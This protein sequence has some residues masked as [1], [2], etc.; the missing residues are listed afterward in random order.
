MSIERLR[1]YKNPRSTKWWDGESTQA[2]ID[3]WSRRASTN[4]DGRRHRATG[5]E[6]VELPSTGEVKVHSTASPPRCNRK[7]DAH[8]AGKDDPN[9]V[10][11]GDFMPGVRREA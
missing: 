1:E 8:M 4:S 3:R 10:S 6:K 9:Y 5:S 7:V 2:N 11:S